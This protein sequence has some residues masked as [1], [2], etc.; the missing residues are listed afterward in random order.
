MLAV[1]PW[2]VTEVSSALSIKVWTGALSIEQRASVQ[3]QWQCMRVA[4]QVML[5]V[6]DSDFETAARF[7]ERHDLNLCAGDA[8]HIAI[9]AAAG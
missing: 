4:S 9:A 3:A 8:L 7:A 6:T 1:S 5:G 2:V